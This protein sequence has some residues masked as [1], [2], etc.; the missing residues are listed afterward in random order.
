MIRLNEMKLENWLSFYT[1][2]TLIKKNCCISTNRNA[3]IMFCLYCLTQSYVPPCWDHSLLPSLFNTRSKMGEIV[4]CN[5]FTFVCTH[6]TWMKET[7]EGFLLSRAVVMIRMHDKKVMWSV[8]E[9]KHNNIL[10]YEGGVEVCKKVIL[11]HSLDYDGWLLNI[12]VDSKS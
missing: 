11:K 5:S 2:F 6:N 8:W 1:Q 3:P 9:K 7:Y 4:R 10:K 12:L